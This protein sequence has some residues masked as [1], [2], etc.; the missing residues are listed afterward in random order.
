MFTGIVTAIGHLTGRDTIEGGLR[1]RID[2]ADLPGEDL[3]LGESIA[4]QGVCLTVAAIVDKRV[5][6]ADVSGETL[7]LTTLGQAGVD[8]PLNLERALRVS[9]RLG[10]HVVSGHVDG[11]GRL[12]SVDPDE[13]S[14]IFR[15]QAPV[16]LMRFLAVKGSIA[17][18]GVSLTI[19]QVDEAGFAVNL[20]PH[21]LQHTTLGRLQHG[22][23]VN[24]EVDPLARYVERLMLWRGQS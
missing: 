12:S 4:V 8:A 14:R 22:D 21:T 23:Q 15:F 3:A 1:L 6:D 16:E 9:D 19:N 13:L 2:A 7:R 20:I 18:D 5:F 10:G 11:M 17:V 24:L